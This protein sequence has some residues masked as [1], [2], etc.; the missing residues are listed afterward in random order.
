LKDINFF[1]R[2]FAIRKTEKEEKNVECLNH[3]T[4]NYPGYEWIVSIRIPLF[5]RRGCIRGFPQLTSTF[6]SV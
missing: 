5:E 3:A 2:N 6:A 1:Y 4:R